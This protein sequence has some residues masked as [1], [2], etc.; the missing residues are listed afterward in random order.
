[1]STT[2]LR[3][4]ITSAATLALGA[5]AIAV[6]TLAMAPTADAQ[7]FNA[8]EYQQMCEQH[9]E[10]FA[11]DATRGVYY[12]QRYNNDREHVCDTYDAN[13]K[14]LGRAISVEYGWYIKHQ[15]ID[16]VSTPPVIKK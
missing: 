10:R 7:V 4:R 8:Q 6:G 11:V 2:S 3:H 16:P 12:T 1:M 9:P 13:G 14:R 5:G 15:P